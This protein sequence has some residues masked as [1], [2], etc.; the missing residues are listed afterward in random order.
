[1][2][3][4]AKPPV[5]TALDTII[6]TVIGTA[7]VVSWLCTGHSGVILILALSSSLWILLDLLKIYNAWAADKDCEVVVSGGQLPLRPKL[8]AQWFGLSLILQSSGL[9]MQLI[10]GWTAFSG[11]ILFF[12]Y[13]GCEIACHLFYYSGTVM[14]NSTTTLPTL[15]MAALVVFFVLSGNGEQRGYWDLGRFGS[16]F[17]VLMCGIGG[18]LSGYF[19][20]QYLGVKKGDERTPL[21]KVPGADSPKAGP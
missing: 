18:M 7:G 6:A 15:A 19:F 12:Y 1:M 10:F 3:P 9:L 11:C 4:D 2:A 13:G 5:P 14:E 16:L 20:L 8:P 21:V 17:W